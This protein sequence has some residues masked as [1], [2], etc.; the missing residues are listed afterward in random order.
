[1]LRNFTVRGLVSRPT[2][3]ECEAFLRIRLLDEQEIRVLFPDA[4]IWHERA[5]GMTKSLVAVRMVQRDGDT[6]RDD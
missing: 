3:D 2:V 6:G 5:L 1:L 4:E